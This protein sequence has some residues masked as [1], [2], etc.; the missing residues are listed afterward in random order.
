MRLTW[1]GQRRRLLK[2][3]TGLGGYGVG[4]AGPNGHQAN[5][6]AHTPTP[7]ARTAKSD[8]TADITIDIDTDQDSG[9][10]DSTDDNVDIIIKPK[11]SAL[12]LDKS[13]ISEPKPSLP[14]YDGTLNFLGTLQARLRAQKLIDAKLHRSGIYKINENNVTEALSP[15]E[16]IRQRLWRRTKATPRIPTPELKA[17]TGIEPQH[18]CAIA[19]NVIASNPG[20]EQGDGSQN[21]TAL[22]PQDSLSINLIPQFS[23]HTAD[24]IDH[25]NNT[26]TAQSTI[27]DDFS[28]DD[29][30]DFGN[31]PNADDDVTSD[32]LPGEERN[33]LSPEELVYI[34]DLFL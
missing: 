29:I 26:N 3:D 18:E 22:V 11:K 23:D 6:A 28:F 9:N 12:K 34:R 16:K 27:D 24:E 31:K 17:K 7:Q 33:E 8:N 25:I 10:Q 2:D 19:G 15:E 4:V 20:C 14:K 1:I 21:L 5:G 30:T 32:D 13:V